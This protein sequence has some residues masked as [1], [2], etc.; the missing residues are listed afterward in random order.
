M[1]FNDDQCP[2]GWTEFALARG[3]YIV[4]AVTI[5][6]IGLTVGEALSDGEER[7]HDHLIEADGFAGGG[8]HAHEVRSEG[9]EHSH[10]LSGN[11]TYEEDYELGFYELVLPSATA[12]DG[13]HTHSIEQDGTTHEHRVQIDGRTGYDEYNNV[14]DIGAPYIQLLVCK[15]D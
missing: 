6:G 3:R 14:D 7:I 15:K 8:D 10:L 9:S 1:F 12:V 5:D 2:P 11:A 4:G 13:A